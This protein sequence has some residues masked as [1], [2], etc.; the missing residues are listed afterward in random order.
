MGAF[1]ARMSHQTYKRSGHRVQLE[2]DE[3]GAGDVSPYSRAGKR[4]KKIEEIN[5]AAA[6]IFVRDGYAQFSARKVFSKRQQSRLY[7]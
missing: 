7:S 2:F 1:D 6:V 4:L 5:D 3:S